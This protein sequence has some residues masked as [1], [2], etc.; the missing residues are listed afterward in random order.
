MGSLP[1]AVLAA[2]LCCFLAVGG[3]AVEL[4]TTDPSPFDVDLNAT[5]ATKYWGPWTPAR[6]TWYGQPN[7]A[8]PDDNGGACGFKHT[9]QYPFASMTSCGNQPLFK[10]GKGCG[11]CYKVNL[12][13]RRRETV[14][15]YCQTRPIPSV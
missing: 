12:I 9:N 14:Y 6:A 4:N 1:L 13:L 11:S 10:D 8:G 5:D 15:S 7:G 2:L 3:G